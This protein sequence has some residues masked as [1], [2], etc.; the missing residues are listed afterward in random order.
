M[1]R[2]MDNNFIRQMMKS[3][4][5]VDLTDEQ[6]LVMKAQTTPE[7]LKYAIKQNTNLNSNSSNSNIVNSS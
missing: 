3:T 6:I 1:F 5:G 4:R 7:K 2:S